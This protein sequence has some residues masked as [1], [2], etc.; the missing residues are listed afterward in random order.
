MRI[1]SVLIRGFR[2]FNE[3]RDIQFDD[4][5][6]LIY[7]PNSYGKTSIS[8]A[9]EWLL[10]G[11]TSR[12]KRAKSKLE[13]R[14][15]YRNVHYSEEEPPGVTLRVIHDGKPIVLTAHLHETD[16]QQRYIGEDFKEVPSGEWPF[17][18]ELERT[19]KPFVLQHALKDLLLASPS[20]RFTGFAQLLGFDELDQIQKDVIALCTSPSI[21]KEVLRIQ[22]LESDLEGELSRLDEMGEVH[23]AFVARKPGLQDLY[24]I[25]REESL[26]RVP[27]G[28]EVESILPQLLLSREEKI[29]KII[30]VDISFPEISDEMN[31]QIDEDSEFFLSYLADDFVN[32]YSRLMALATLSDIAAHESFLKYGLNRYEDEPGECPFCGKKLSGAEVDH[33]Q[34]V[35]KKVK[36]EAG[37][38]LKL[39]SKRRTM[40]RRIEDLER[41]ANKFYDQHVKRLNRLLASETQMDKLSDILKE[42]HSAHLENIKTAFEDL[43]DLV[44][45]FNKARTGVISAV[46]LVAKSIKDGEEDSELMKS[47]S[48]EIPDY[49]SASE[50][51][52]EAIEIHANLLKEADQ[53]LQKELDGLAKTQ[54]ISI[55]IK[56]LES[57]K[58]LEKGLEIEG[59]LEGL[60][61]L[62]RS[63]D[64]FV[65]DRMLEAVAGQ[66]SKDVLR[67]YK[68]IKTTG[69]P[70]IHFEGFDLERT[71]K[72]KIKARRVEV[73]AKSY[74]E[75]LVS[76]VSSLSESKLNALGLCM[77]LAMNLSEESPF[78]FVLI[79]DPIQSLD[80]DH[81]TQF[82]QVIRKVSEESNQI[83][84]LSHNKPWLDQVRSGCR[85]LNGTYYEITGYTEKGPVIKRVPW[86]RWKQR[87]DTV[88]AILKNTKA[89]TVQLQQAEEELRLTFSELTAAIY[90]RIKEKE[91]HSS[92]L[93]ATKL[94]K[95]LIECGVE[96]SMIDRIAQAYE[97]IDPAH[98]SGPGYIPN[99]DRIKKYHSWAHELAQQL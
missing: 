72:G 20:E 59:V 79:D 12:V 13:F 17:E 11:S 70:D 77:S 9:F 83:I 76:A 19:P 50:A 29:S 58:K 67:W 36:K 71:K 62:R 74:G 54:D 1:N 85:S 80:E 3:E 18:T 46:E 51:L 47:L 84:L 73:K 96:A 24:K 87:L 52:R 15:S 82:V 10:Y 34:K 23:K 56:L 33:I 26:K 16:E 39:K 92:S 81:A 48:T 64:D 98:H 25:V 14:G 6:T 95:K 97:T 2:G 32:Q 35:H 69:D 44:K 90:A 42:N 49:I 28:T 4:K 99:R 91:I 89:T 60:K 66:M 78:E 37:E 68:K 43:G 55:L 65:A 63:V 5:L 86:V 38:A 94:R 21:P 53:I 8:E 41:R 88:D 31:K 61:D 75:E 57:R 40:R 27:A 30:K 93:N 45:R 7:A 22:R